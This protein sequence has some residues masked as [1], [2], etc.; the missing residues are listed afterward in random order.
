MN[1]RLTT[2]ELGYFYKLCDQHLIEKYGTDLIGLLNLEISENKTEIIMMLIM[3][4]ND[5]KK[6]IEK[7]DIYD[8]VYKSIVPEPRK[9][10]SVP[11]AVRT[12]AP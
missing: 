10:I 8:F 7:Y 12:S 5:V 6:C 4:F 2:K 11:C 1:N 9:R 3:Q